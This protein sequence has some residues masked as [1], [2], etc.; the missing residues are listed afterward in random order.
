LESAYRDAIMGDFRALEACLA[1]SIDPAWRAVFEAQR[2]AAGLADTLAPPAA[3]SPLDTLERTR[4]AAVM[5]DTA[6]V[7][8]VAN[9]GGSEMAM[10][11]WGLLTGRPDVERALACEQEA[12][13]AG[14]ADQVVE[15]ASLAALA[16]LASD[17]LVRATSLAR[18]ASRMART[19][20]MPQLEYL[21]HLVLARVRRSNGRPHLATRILLAL[22][23]TAP[24]HWQGWIALELA[25][26]GAPRAARELADTAAPSPAGS[27]A[28]ALARAFEALES[29]SLPSFAAARAALDAAP[30]F[31]SEI[32][33]IA[34]AIDLR[35]DPDP[36]IAPFVRGES[37]ALPPS[38]TGAARI[39][40]AGVTT[41][42]M[43]ALADRPARRV[44][45][46]AVRALGVPLLAAR[47][48]RT[49]VAIAILLAE[50]PL[51]RGELFARI[52]GFAFDA[53][54]HGGVFDVLLHRM[55][56][57]LGERAD[58]VRE[59][60]IFR[61]DVREPFAVPDP[62]CERPLDDRVLRAL[63]E[64]GAM[65]AKDAA[66]RLGVPLRTVQALLAQLVEEGECHADK[67]GRRVQYRVEDTTFSEPTQRSAQTP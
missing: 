23:R 59:G 56:A 37:H 24:R 34:M 54:L 49:E 35:V 60:D 11:W 48:P 3:R 14:A 57:Y 10:I 40:I 67:N 2:F 26:A 36:H 12:L 30:I 65:S 33:A 19:E 45:G 62:R 16:A 58:L 7:A 50:G 47:Q 8:R 52:Y 63:A 6:Q 20:A 42:C 1:S 43:I 39:E 4:I 13:R 25:L 29:G 44:L 17:D 5:L 9:G 31:A 32:D 41:P 28:L 64:G 55:R 53:A 18:R 15:A 38:L 61:I 51:A 66:Q 21:A 27:A 22:A 46:A